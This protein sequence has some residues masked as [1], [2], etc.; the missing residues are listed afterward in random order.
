MYNKNMKSFKINNKYSGMQIYKVIGK[1]FESLG[2]SSIDKLFRIKDIK[3]NGI[4]VDKKHIV[5]LGDDVSIYAS[6]SILFNVPNEI[7]YFYEDE[8][9]LI[10]Y[11]P[12]NILSCGSLVAFET[13]HKLS[14]EDL[15]KK[16]KP[17]TNI[18]IC[19]RLD[20]NTEGLVIL[21]KNNLSNLEIVKAFKN[22]S[23]KKE[24]L[25]LVSGKM[26]KETGILSDYLEKDIATAY[27]KVTKIKHRFSLPIKTEYKVLKYFSKVDLS[28]LQV[29]L[30]TGRT[31]QI[32]AHMKFI[33]HAVIGDSKYG[34]NELN[35]RFGLSSQFLIAYSYSFNFDEESPLFYLNNVKIS[36][37]E[38][39]INIPKWIKD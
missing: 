18:K 25:T 32:R 31:H 13:K 35:R 28:L 3:V 27:V 29:I 6:D 11:K 38:N 8:N 24:Y 36:L 16:D 26:E 4:R 15:I 33:G 23:I 5:D 10:A 39:K 34:S 22:K 37:D 19:H 9:I 17:N 30:H 7:V 2:K 1:E 12:K 20:T 21:S 14:F